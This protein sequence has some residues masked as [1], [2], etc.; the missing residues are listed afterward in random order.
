MLCET[1][2][3]GSGTKV[4]PRTVASN[5]GVTARNIPPKRLPSAWA[6]PGGATTRAKRCT[7]K[8]D[9]REG[10]EEKVQNGSTRRK[11]RE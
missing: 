5:K 8:E 10:V 3:A 11:V 7:V 9:L 6:G 2:D 1:V 4:T